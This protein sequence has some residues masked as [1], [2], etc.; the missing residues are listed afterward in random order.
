MKSDCQTVGCSSNHSMCHLTCRLG[1]CTQTFSPGLRDPRMAILSPSGMASS[2]CK[3]RSLLIAGIAVLWTSG[4]VRT[5]MNRRWCFV[6]V[7]GPTASREL[8]FDEARTLVWCCHLREQHFLDW[9]VH[10]LSWQP[11]S[12]S[13]FWSHRLDKCFEKMLM[14][15]L[16]ISRGGRSMAG[17]SWRDICCLRHLASFSSV[18]SICR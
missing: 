8:H 10:M 4:C 14:Q 5:R 6:M 13:A 3:V 11:T 9:S 16:L 2:I 7:Q 1:R 18:Q 12:C 17:L 15:M